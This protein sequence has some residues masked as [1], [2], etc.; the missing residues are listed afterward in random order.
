MCLRS[1]ACAQGC[2]GSGVGKTGSV[3]VQLVLQPSTEQKKC[4]AELESREEKKNSLG[5]LR[6]VGAGIFIPIG[7]VF[8]VDLGVFAVIT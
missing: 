2:G 8:F 3:V 7:E 1:A 4:N 6:L 5:T